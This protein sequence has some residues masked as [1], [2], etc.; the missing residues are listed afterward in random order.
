MDIS[1]LP[2]PYDYRNPVR[3]A[4]LFAGRNAEIASIAYELDQAGVDRPSVYIAV[5]GRRAA[6]KTSL[7]NRTEHLARDRGLLPVRVELVEG[8]DSPAAFYRKV[9]EELVD[10]VE[11]EGAPG[12]VPCGAS[13][14][15]PATV[16]AAQVRRVFSGAA[17]EAGFPLEFPEALAL[18]GS[19]GTV[20]Q[21]ALR[22]DLR[23]LVRALGR[24][25]ALLIDEAQLVA[26]HKEVLSILRALGS[27][28][29][30]FV[31]VLAGT[32]GLLTQITEVFSPL[33][34]QF[35]EIRTE[36]FIEG[37]DVSSCMLLPLRRLGMDAACFPDFNATQ[38]E[39]VK[40]TDGN[41]YEIQLY[42]HEMFA[43][44]QKDPAM[45]GMALSAEMLEDVRSRMEQGR[46]VLDRRLIRSV[47]KLSPERLHAFNVLSSALDHATVD[48]V[49]FAHNV[50][51]APTIT[52]EVL[53]QARAQ[54]IADG[55]LDDDEVVRL[56]Q[57]TELFDDIYVRLWTINKLGRRLHTQLMGRGE[58]RSLLT[59]RL[60]CLLTELA[61]E[62]AR[63]LRTCCPKMGEASLNEALFA[64]ESL[65]D[66]GAESVPHPTQFV[67]EAILRTGIPTALDITTVTCAYRG[68]TAVQWLYSA[69]SDDFLLDT[70]PG[71]RAAADRIAALGGELTAE[72]TRL[73]LK[74]WSKISEWLRLS[75]GAV[76][77]AIACNHLG[78]SYSAY[79]AGDLAGT[80]THLSAAFDLD[81]RWEPANNILYVSLAAGEPGIALEWVGR[82]VDMAQ[83]PKDKALS[84]YNAAMAYLLEGDRQAAADQLAL[85][86]GELAPLPFVDCE[87]EYLLTPRIVDGE[88]ALEQEREVDL[89]G[90][91]EGARAAVGAEGETASV[92][93][94]EIV[95]E[96]AG[97]E[98]AGAPGSVEQA[99]EPGAAVSASG[100]PSEAPAARAGEPRPVTVLVVATEWWSAHGGLSTFNRDLCRALAAAGA[101][102]YC[103]VLAASQEEIDEAEVANVSLLCRPSAAG[104]PEYV[105]LTRRP[106]LPEGTVP[107][108]VIGHSRIT[109]PAAEMLVSDFFPQAR[110]LHFIHMAPDEIE[111]HKLD[112]DDDAALRAEGRTEEE[113][114][115]GTGAHRVVTVGPRLH[116]RFLNE[117]FGAGVSAPLQIDP[118]FDTADAKPRTPP[119][120]GPLKVLLVGRTEDYELKGLD[121]AARACGQVAT[122][123]E[124]AQVP[125]IGL[126]VRGAPSGTGTEQRKQLR[127]W[128]GH[129]KMEIVV[130]EYSSDEE[131]LTA[132]MCRA[133][134][135][136][137]PSRAEGFGLVGVEAMTLGVPTLVSEE[138]GLAQLLREKLDGETAGRLIVPM[139]GDDDE[140]AETW[141]RH[142]DAVMRDLPTAFRRAAEVRD[143]LAT[144]VT[145]ADAAAKLLGEADRGEG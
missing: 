36:R 63:V 34:R 91:I 37:E 104:V 5:H 92:E 81:P 139:S 137:M 9:Y 83:H 31:F 59:R 14:V 51:G 61:A 33:L 1:K 68:T 45:G 52:R 108:L 97:T 74:P 30:G 103:A 4:A 25:I 43:R 111:W 49:W 102:V 82:A 88:V 55:T 54:L 141:A 95:A 87:I 13:T 10:A 29:D 94:T 132:D 127:T 85:A 17:P 144:E 119:A 28:L 72:R 66:K 98:S 125:A 3:D 71:F 23:Y 44:W 58:F 40:L 143:A 90:A 110:R 38:S 32:S 65:A 24:P 109:G 134:L 128:S 16:S 26:G 69:D 84:R 96:A 41:P 73:P 11:A 67:H 21:A 7:L 2:N 117:L 56:S 79:R 101:Q 50:V 121:L 123:R 20:S 75:T 6:G 130:R 129:P 8:D 78:A 77:S 135:V 89:A 106:Q 48:E 112:R 120:G 131:R 113:R 93:G 138:S 118:G 42:C 99:A 15:P 70:T 53:D 57:E 122:W 105:R 18:S 86:A 12:E 107:D 39:I 136:I 115:L 64:L 27:R 22:A 60:G 80:R 47:K 62:P 124:K 116:H 133:S 100:A 140:D 145:W 114:R 142:I 46:E 126:L 19:D 35:K 76:R